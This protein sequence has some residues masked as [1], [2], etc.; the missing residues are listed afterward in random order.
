MASTS[1]T[2]KPHFKEG[3]LVGYQIPKLSDLSTGVVLKKWAPYGYVPVQDVAEDP[4][5]GNGRQRNIP[6]E[7]LQL[8]AP[9]A[10]RTWFEANE[11]VAVQLQHGSV[12][13]RGVVKKAL[14]Q[15]RSRY[16]VEVEVEEDYDD[17]AVAVVERGKKAR[18]LVK[19]V[20]VTKLRVRVLGEWVAGSSSARTEQQQGYLK[21]VIIKQEKLPEAT[22]IKY[23]KWRRVEVAINEEGFEGAWFTADIVGYIDPNGLEYLVQFVNLM[24]DDSQRPLIESVAFKHIRPC[25]PTLARPYHFRVSE[26]VDCWHHDGWWRGEVIV[27]FP[28]CAK[29]RVYFGATGENLEFEYERM[30]PHLE[31]I[32][33]DWVLY[34]A[35]NEEYYPLVEDSSTS[36]ANTT[37]GERKYKFV[38]GM[39]VEVTKDLRAGSFFN[40]TIS[41]DQ[42]PNE[43]YLV[44]YYKLFG[45]E[46]I[47]DVVQAYQI[48]PVPPPLHRERIMTVLDLVDVRDYKDRR[49]WSAVVVGD[50]NCSKCVTVT[51]FETG[52]QWVCDREA[53][54]FHQEWI[55]GVWV[56]V[57]NLQ[58]VVRIYPAY[59]VVTKTYPLMRCTDGSYV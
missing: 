11:R 35:A 7:E 4:S 16:L 32:D 38:K 19:E 21:S 54:R 9:A 12:W 18:M 33:G 25:P 47:V 13:R 34:G 39:E 10:E 24:T 56:D 50:S 55:D 58:D 26:F 37:S 27:R 36:T 17:G 8:L 5:L 40:A 57:N 53:L 43:S 30:R 41:D 22:L 15:A 45:V 3:D 1:G 20:E 14:D 52:E 59:T 44:C 46:L 28:D 29:Y 31:W 48:R 49:W 42:L 51:I 6:A 23:E 2:N